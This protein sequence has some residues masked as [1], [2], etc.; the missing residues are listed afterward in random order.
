MRG[1][2][3]SPFFSTGGDFQRWDS[4]AKGG[5][6]WSTQLLRRES[7]ILRMHVI[8]RESKAC[9]QAL[10]QISIS[11]AMADVLR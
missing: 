3:P 9:L 4:M 5:T 8:Y 10:P 11:D 6:A 2:I 7:P 1:S